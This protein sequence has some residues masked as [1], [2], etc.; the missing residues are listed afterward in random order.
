MIDMT[1]R[2]NWCALLSANRAFPPLITHARTGKVAVGKKRLPKCDE[3]AAAF[4]QR[5][6]LLDEWVLEKPCEP[7][8]CMLQLTPTLIVFSSCHKPIGVEIKLRRVRED[9]D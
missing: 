8:L 6:K 7:L 1:A 2:F 3:F 4:D 9:L 5:R